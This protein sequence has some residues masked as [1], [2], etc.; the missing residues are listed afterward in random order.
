M[1]LNSSNE[2][3]TGERG[4]TRKITALVWKRLMLLHSTKLR[5]FV[6]QSDSYHKKWE[7]KFQELCW[8]KKEHGHI[9]ISHHDVDNRSLFDWC[10]DQPQAINS[11]SRTW[12][13]ITRKR[14]ISLCSIEFIFSKKLENRHKKYDQL[15]KY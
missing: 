13:A 9:C 2:D 1:K 4:A 12:T 3:F 11:P 6:K 8:Y 7:N 15:M 10:Q 5:K 14:F